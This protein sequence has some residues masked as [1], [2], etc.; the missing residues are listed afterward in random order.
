M[1]SPSLLR[2]LISVR[3]SHRLLVEIVHVGTSQLGRLKS[4]TV[5]HK[6]PYTLTHHTNEEDKRHHDR[7]ALLRG[8]DVYTSSVSRKIYIE[9]FLLP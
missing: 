3:G 4:L 1:I 6:I 8:L 2:G 7:K 5:R 9:N